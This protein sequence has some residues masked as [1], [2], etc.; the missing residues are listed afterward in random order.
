MV[1]MVTLA[2]VVWFIQVSDISPV[3]NFLCL[4]VCYRYLIFFF[5]FVFWFCL[6][7]VLLFVFFFSTERSNRIKVSSIV[8]QERQINK[9]NERSQSPNALYNQSNTYHVHRSSDGDISILSLSD[10]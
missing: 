3:L 6:L 7:V 4:S 1:I 9:I 8:E 5:V 10:S 2:E